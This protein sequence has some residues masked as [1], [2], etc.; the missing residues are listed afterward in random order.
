MKVFSISVA[1]PDFDHRKRE[2][3]LFVGGGVIVLQHTVPNRKDQA[4]LR[5]Q[6]NQVRTR[7]RRVC[8]GAVPFLLFA[9]LDALNSFARD[10]F[11]S[12][13]GMRQGQSRFRGSVIWRSASAS[14]QHIR[15]AGH[16]KLQLGHSQN[17]GADRASFA[18]SGRWN[19]EDS[20]QNRQSRF[21]WKS[22]RITHAKFFGTDAK[23]SS[24]HNFYCQTKTRIP[25]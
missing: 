19:A 24:L 4:D 8:V 2:I 1:F 15:R 7:S 14:K 13:N 23:K 22:A 5:Q 11:P 16:P 18:R 3:S 17:R 12:L 10:N 20:Q 6:I 25:R 21:C 9:I